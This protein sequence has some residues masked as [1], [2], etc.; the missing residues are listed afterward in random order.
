MDEE[1]D[2]CVRMNSFFK[3]G[4]W[5]PDAYKQIFKLRSG[6]DLPT[7][8]VFS[9]IVYWL[10]PRKNGKK[11]YYGKQL[12]LSVADISKQT[13]LSKRQ[14]GYAL[15]KLENKYKFINRKVI[16]TLVYISLNVEI[17]EKVLTDSFPNLFNKTGGEE[18]TCQTHIHKEPHRVFSSKIPKGVNEL[19]ISD[20]DLLLERIE[21]LKVEVDGKKNEIL[22]HEMSYQK[23]KSLNNNTKYVFNENLNCMT[24]EELLE[25]YVFDNESVYP[26]FSRLVY[27]YNYMYV[28]F[29]S[30]S[31]ESPESMDSDFKNFLKEVSEECSVNMDIYRHLT[32]ACKGLDT[33]I[34]NLDVDRAESYIT[35]R[36]SNLTS[37]IEDHERDLFSLSS[38]LKGM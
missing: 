23:F 3:R 10:S 5:V 13:Y 9:K 30:K 38:H 34:L 29:I 28:D 18:Q 8:V 12:K 21:N 27:M 37:E 14:V 20:K 16:G 1:M 17:I 22:R 25:A 26:A 19:E 24:K 32:K 7:C 4:D 31:T 35:E 11:K 33:R 36:R 15:E 6:T 2:L